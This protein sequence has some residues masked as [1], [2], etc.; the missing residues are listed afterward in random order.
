MPT[1]EQLNRQ[2]E[3]DFEFGRN[4]DRGSEHYDEKPFIGPPK[5][6]DKVTG[7]TLGLIVWDKENG[8]MKVIPIK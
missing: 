4:I 2:W 3:V 8:D 6:L 5:I 1:I 7:E